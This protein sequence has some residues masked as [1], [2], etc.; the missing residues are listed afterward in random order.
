M[1]VRS[2]R[3]YPYKA[4]AMAHGWVYYPTGRQVQAAEGKAYLK[5]RKL[6]A[7]IAILPHQRQTGTSC[8]CTRDELIGS[9]N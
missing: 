3:R 5:I 8:R 9:P 2:R 1:L 7:V 4:G 6:A